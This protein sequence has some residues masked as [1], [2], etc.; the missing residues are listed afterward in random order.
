MCWLKM[1]FVSG[2]SAGT[3]QHKGKVIK[4]PGVPSPRCGPGLCGVPSVHVPA[5]TGAR[6]YV[7]VKPPLSP[8]PALP[9]ALLAL[10]YAPEKRIRQT[11]D[12]TLSQNPLNRELL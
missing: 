7:A 5:R 11:L 9:P 1:H 4:Q 3:G 6:S 2:G 12:Q 8:L 10:V